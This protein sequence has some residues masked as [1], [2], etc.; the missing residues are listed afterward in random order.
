M[1]K[2]VGND[3]GVS[4]D[5][6]STYEDAG[7]LLDER[8]DAKFDGFTRR[9]LTQYQQIKDRQYGGDVASTDILA[10]L[11]TA[12]SL[13]GLT[14]RQRLVI[15]SVHID[16]THTQADLS[17]AL[18]VSKK[19]ISVHHSKALRKIAVI[20]EAWDWRDKADEFKVV[21]V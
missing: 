10:D 16:G 19:V 7:A 15:D 14:D 5:V 1:T 21:G 13:A 6:G 20:Y 2:V 9:L 12:I 17:R 4:Q 3:V 11:A 18:G 8:L